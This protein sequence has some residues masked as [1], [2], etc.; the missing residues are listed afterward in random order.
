MR[1]SL[2]TSAL[3]RK[4]ATVKRVSERTVSIENPFPINETLIEGESKPE[5]HEIPSKTKK[6]SIRL[7]RGKR[8]VP[9]NK[10]ARSHERNASVMPMKRMKSFETVAGIP[11]YGITKKGRILNVTRIIV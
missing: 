1:R 9:S 7:D 3:T 5:T 10:R 8:S 11:K 6:P 4:S 2:V